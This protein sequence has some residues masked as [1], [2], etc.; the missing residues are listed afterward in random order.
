M[1]SEE[2]TPAVK[3]TGLKNMKM[4]VEIQ[5]MILKGKKMSP[6]SAAI[7]RASEK[8]RRAGARLSL[9]YAKMRPDSEKMSSPGSDISLADDTKKSDGKK[10]TCDYEKMKGRDLIKGL[11]LEK[12]RVAR[13]RKRTAFE[14]K[15]FESDRMSAKVQTKSPDSENKHS[16][17]GK[18]KIPFLQMDI[19]ESK[20]IAY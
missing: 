7:S 2:M 4:Q 10:M 5:K 14:T 6:E 17:I 12:E 20:K 9:A 15:H 18:M 1:N 8:I 16:V 11:A 19:S 13:R 3:Q